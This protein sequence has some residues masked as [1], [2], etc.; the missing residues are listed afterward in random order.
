MRVSLEKPISGK[1]KEKNVTEVIN[2]LPTELRKFIS[3]ELSKIKSSSKEDLEKLSG[4]IQDYFDKKISKVVKKSFEEINLKKINDLV[5]AEKKRKE[6]IIEEQEIKSSIYLTGVLLDTLGFKDEARF[7]TGLATEIYNAY[8]LTSS[9]ASIGTM[10]AVAGYVG[11]A[12]A[13]YGLFSRK[14]KSN[15]IGKALRQISKQIQSLREE[16]HL[17]FDAIEYNQRIIIDSIEKIALE[18]NKSD[19]EISKSL[20][21]IITNIHFD[22]KINYDNLQDA[23]I[24]KLRLGANQLRTQFGYKNNLAEKYHRPTVDENLTI[25][26][27]YAFEVS[28]DKIFTGSSYDTL[29]DIIENDVLESMRID[30]SLNLLNLFQSY[31]NIPIDVKSI[32]NPIEFSRGA[33]SFCTHRLMFQEV[34]NTVYDTN[35]KLLY[36]EALRLRE[37]LKI[38]TSKPFVEKIINSF[39]IELNTFLD[40]MKVKIDVDI[41]SKELGLKHLFTSMPTMKTK[42]LEKTKVLNVSERIPSNSFLLKESSDWRF[43][44]EFFKIDTSKKNSN[45]I[46]LAELMGLITLKKKNTITRLIKGLHFIKEAEEIVTIY[47][48]K[49]HHKSMNRITSLWHS[50]NV[51]YYSGGIT[52]KP[53]FDPS[54]NISY[55]PKEGV[56][57]HAGYKIDDTLKFLKLLEAHIKTVYFEA[58]ASFYDELKILTSKKN[59]YKSIP[60]LLGIRY[61]SSFSF[62]YQTQDLENST[63]ILQNENFV[64]SKKY[65]DRITNNFVAKLANEEAYIHQKKRPISKFPGFGYQTIGKIIT[66]NIGKTII[67]DSKPFLSELLDF[68]EK[69]SNTYGGNENIEET[70]RNIVAL[71]KFSNL[72]IL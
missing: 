44:G 66:E 28:E 12:I 52:N 58:K 11:I 54:I 69:K 47:E 40:S 39:Y 36:F 13:I 10:T 15:G 5:N 14:K 17:R 22:R 1:I 6:K 20:N 8:K 67:T 43:F 33:T 62:W 9:L 56:F 53:K 70:L 2:N 55:L 31:Y 57:N 29:D 26:F 21:D 32:R 50:S 7:I 37:T 41:V 64:I 72:D 42:V 4:D 30:S 16:M 38:P 71:S 59:L 34:K 65:L 18:I 35:V 27:D 3:D 49:F 63:K 61:I 45:P 46:Q 24:N 68:S 51:R 25:L 60:S 19:E 23:K 48:I